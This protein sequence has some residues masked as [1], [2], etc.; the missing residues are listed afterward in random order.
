M[1]KSYLELD[2]TESNSVM[3]GAS[4]TAS[5]VFQHLSPQGTNILFKIG[6]SNDNTQGGSSIHIIPRFENDGLDLTCPPLPEKPNLDQIA[7]KIRDKTFAISYKEKKEEIERI[8]LDKP[9]TMLQD[10]ISKA[11]QRYRE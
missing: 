3:M 6:N 7:E 5:A 1:K 4:T 9:E 10:E 11:I 2:K 8:D